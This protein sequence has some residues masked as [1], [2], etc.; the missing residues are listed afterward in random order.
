LADDEFANYTRDARRSPANSA[1]TV[2]QSIFDEPL[3]ALY[4]RLKNE[5]IRP[6]PWTLKNVA[7]EKSKANNR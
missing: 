7:L 5:K 4:S 3:A 1:P 6:R 2:V